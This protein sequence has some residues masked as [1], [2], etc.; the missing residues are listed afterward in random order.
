MPPK[1]DPYRKQK[2]SALTS[3]D[4]Q[5]VNL[6]SSSSEEPTESER[7]SSITRLPSSGSQTNSP[8]RPK[9]KGLGQ[10]LRA[11]LRIANSDSSDD[12]NPLR[13]ALLTGK[14]SVKRG[15]PSNLLQTSTLSRKLSTTE[16]RPYLSIELPRKKNEAVISLTDD[17]ERK[18]LTQELALLLMEWALTLELGNNQL[19]RVAMITTS[20]GNNNK[21]NITHD[22]PPS[23]MTE[24]FPEESGLYAFAAEGRQVIIAPK[25]VGSSFTLTH[26]IP[27]GVATNEELSLN[28]VSYTSLY[29]NKVKCKIKK[30]NIRIAID[31]SLNNCNKKQ[32]NP[33]YSAFFE[34]S[35]FERHQ[36]IGRGVKAVTSLKNMD[37][38]FMVK[39]NAMWQDLIQRPTSNL[40]QTPEGPTTFWDF[41][42]KM[43]LE[44]PGLPTLQQYQEMKVLEQEITDLTAKIDEKQK[45]INDIK[46]GPKKAEKSKN[47]AS[48]RENLAALE[49]KLS[50]KKEAFAAES[51][52]DFINNLAYAQRGE[53]TDPHHFTEARIRTMVESLRL[54]LLASGAAE[55]PTSQRRDTVDVRPE[56][57]NE[58][59]EFLLNCA[60][61]GL[62]QH[63]KPELVRWLMVSLSQGG[64]YCITIGI[65]DAII[66]KLLG[67]SLNQE[68]FRTDPHSNQ[69]LLHL[70]SANS[71]GTSIS[72]THSLRFTNDGQ[73]WV[74]FQTKIECEYRSE[75]WTTTYTPIIKS[76]QELNQK[77]KQP[78]ITAEIENLIKPQKNILE[79]I[80]NDQYEKTRK[81]QFKDLIQRSTTIQIDTMAGQIP[82]AEFMSSVFDN[83]R[84]D[85]AVGIADF[86]LAKKLKTINDTLGNDGTTTYS[87]NNIRSYIL[88]LM[89]YAANPR[90]GE[91]TPEHDAFGRLADIIN[92]HKR[93][94]RRQQT[95]QNPA[96][97]NLAGAGGRRTS[98]TTDLASSSAAAGFDPFSGLR[99]NQ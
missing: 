3:D 93:T 72:M 80:L 51:N 87:Y 45:V 33:R 34:R 55:V 65:A 27:Y 56:M 44:F 1:K 86:D 78:T 74:T 73:Q 7:K 19:A 5:N 9:D 48:R 63:M 46:P 4:M 94:C 2:E 11:A 66:F 82:L 57:T 39:R 22:L 76:N 79:S 52:N 15:S 21:Y 24:L 54:K 13:I 98:A 70:R 62:A 8:E 58:V 69:V 88:T 30:G 41:T 32:S 12:D 84:T 85:L 99:P 83:L 17:Q 26:T 20:Q 31:P 43:A 64:P 50:E 75:S 6:D 14:P 29:K 18:I 90:P 36:K 38:F 81:N 37:D 61:V 25:E 35:Q 59:E 10:K 47:Q 53:S 49:K 89:T 60:E 95:A 96:R 91:T 23:Y 67:E 68:H 40:I 28:K 71:Q 42:K 16:E 77:L 97:I 92:E